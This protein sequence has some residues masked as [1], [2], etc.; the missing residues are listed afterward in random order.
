[1]AFPTVA[2]GLVLILI[3][4]QGYFDFGGLLG[5]AG[6]SPTALI[7]AAVGAVLAICG[8]LSLDDRW[9]KHAMHLAAMV[10]LVG[11]LGAVWRP[12]KAL[13]ETGTVDLSAVPVR[14]QLATAALCL[15]F[16][17][18]CVRSFVAARR[19]RAGRDAREPGGM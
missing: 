5:V 3:G 14:L 11:F 15:L 13:V 9:R 19:A 17:I 10:G 8:A 18:L 4:L 7:P 16:V 2:I 1:V 6:R 12:A